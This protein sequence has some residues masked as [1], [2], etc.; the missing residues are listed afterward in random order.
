MNVTTLKPHPMDPH[1]NAP[2]ATLD[3]LQNHIVLLERQMRQMVGAQDRLGTRV[4][5]M[6]TRLVRL[7]EVHDLDAEGH[8]F[9]K[10]EN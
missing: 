4:V 8:L 7:M 1:Y 5:R 9:T 2:A 10:R 6:E 3:T